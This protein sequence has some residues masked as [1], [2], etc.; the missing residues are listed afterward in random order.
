MLAELERI[1]ERTHADDSVSAGG[2]TKSMAGGSKQRCGRFL[3]PLAQ[4]SLA[5]QGKPFDP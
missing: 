3:S 4:V 5:D 2:D 1:A